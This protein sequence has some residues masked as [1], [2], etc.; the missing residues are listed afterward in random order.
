MTL[1]KVDRRV[2]KHC[3]R[4]DVG[5]GSRSQKVLIDIYVSVAGAGKRKT[6]GLGNSLPLLHKR[7]HVARAPFLKFL[8]LMSSATYPL[9]IVQTFSL[10]FFA[11]HFNPAVNA[12]FL[13]GPGSDGPRNVSPGKFS[14]GNVG[15]RM[16]VREVADESLVNA[17]FANGPYRG[18]YEVCPGG[19]REPSE[20]EIQTSL[21]SNEHC[22][23]VTCGRWRGGTMI[24]QMMR[25]GK[26][27]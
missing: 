3:L 12:W 17:S 21:F 9:H 7:H 22:S 24:V 5:R 2:G 18:R 1:V 8:V 11:P 15:P 25:G 16:S 10:L 6:K 23:S 14:P 20:I 27:R 13:N 4:R 19:D 26:A